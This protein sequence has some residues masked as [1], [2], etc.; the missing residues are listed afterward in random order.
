MKRILILTIATVFVCFSGCII[1]NLG[2]LNAVK[3]E[4]RQ[5]IFEIYVAEFSKVKANGFFDINYYSEPSDTIE[6]KVHPNLLE[7]FIFEVIDDELVIR[8][9]KR[10]SYGENE[11]AVVSISMP[12]LNGI[13]IDGFGR[14]LGGFGSMNTFTAVDKISSDS[15]FITIAGA[16]GGRVELDVDNLIVD[17]FGAGK[18]ELSGRAGTSVL[19]LSGAGELDALSLQTLNTTINLS[20]A[21]TLSIYCSDNLTINA[22]GAGSV[23]YRGAPNI[24]L[25]TGGAVNIKQL[26]Y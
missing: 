11:T 6:L 16:G 5:E 8:T 1:V 7:Y 13:T 17:V 19:N 15:F 18:L 2:D 14:S 21:G 24:N 12:T 23:V 25:N 20:G 3:P 22:S 10:I 9:S 4:G 26:S